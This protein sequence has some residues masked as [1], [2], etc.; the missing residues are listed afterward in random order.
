MTRLLQIDTRSAICCCIVKSAEMDTTMF[1]IASAAT[2]L[3]PDLHLETSRLILRRFRDDDLDALAA[4]LADPETTQYLGR[5]LTR[6]R[7]QSQGMLNWIHEHWQ[8]HGYGLQ[9]LEDKAGGE[10]LGWSGFIDEP[11]W[12]GF[13]LGWALRRTSWGM[14]YAT[15]A[16][17][18][19]LA[20]ARD[21]LKKP[22]VISMIR[23]PNLA[24][25][26]VAHKLGMVFDKEIELFD[27]PI[28][29]YQI[30]FG[31]V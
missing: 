14:G 1:T 9:A 23:R 31:G 19:M 7:T 27:K 29:L 15:E 11:D 25:V 26:R 2:V 6:D 28:D 24:S 21:V 30:R 18:P 12:P 8:Q 10:L 16:S 5:G 17:L 13:E 4:M 22:T 3:P 20:L